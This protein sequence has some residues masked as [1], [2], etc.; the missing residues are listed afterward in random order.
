MTRRLFLVT[1]LIMALMAGAPLVADSYYYES[2]TTTK[3][4]NGQEQ[5]DT[6]RGWV[7]G[8]N[9]RLEYPEGG[10]GGRVDQGMYILTNNAGETVFMVNPKDKA[11][12]EFDLAQLMSLADATAGMVQLEF[13]DVSA[14]KLSEGPG[15]AVLGHDTTKYKLRSQFIMEMNV[16][17]MQRVSQVESTSDLWM[18]REVGG[19]SW[20]MWLK[21]MPSSGDANQ[22]LEWAER[23][24][25]TNG[26]AGLAMR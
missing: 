11:Y 14:E 2:V 23:S 17:G 22:F 7:D 4:G 21:M 20:T 3:A 10:Q 6:V 5:R 16:M 9:V 19:E 15:G 26:G 8:K 13:R 12:F 1:A 24:G 25:V 18:T